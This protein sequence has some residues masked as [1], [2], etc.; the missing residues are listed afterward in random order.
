[1]QQRLQTRI[2]AQGKYLQAILCKAQE[3]ISVD[4]MS[5]PISTNNNHSNQENILFSGH[6]NNNNKEMKS[7]FDQIYPDQQDY[8]GDLLKIKHEAAA[9][10]NYCSLQLNLNNGGTTTTNNN[11][12]EF[13]G[14]YRR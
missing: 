2:E 10:G 5:C 9:S 14:A 3:G 6:V 4:H 8:K 11:N 7:V 1:M 12:Y 13:G